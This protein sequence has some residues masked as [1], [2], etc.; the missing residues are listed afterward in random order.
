MGGVGHTPAR[1]A[2][3]GRGAGAGEPGVYHL[4]RSSLGLAGLLRGPGS[5]LCSLPPLDNLERALRTLRADVES[6]SSEL[7]VHKESGGLVSL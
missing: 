1:P 2:T 4:I 3:E 5:R 7:L 6:F